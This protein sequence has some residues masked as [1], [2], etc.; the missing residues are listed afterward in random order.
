[1]LMRTSSPL[2]LLT[3]WPTSIIG[4]G[5]QG[6]GPWTTGLIIGILEF[7]GNALIYGVIGSIIGAIAG[8]LRDGKGRP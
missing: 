4:F 5:Y 8:K 7:G 2:L 3:L 6:E 1:M